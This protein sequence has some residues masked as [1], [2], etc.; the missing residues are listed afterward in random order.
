[1]TFYL[2]VYD[3]VTYGKEIICGYIVFNISIY[4]QNIA[5]LSVNIAI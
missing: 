4:C 2:P 5:L 3:S 1:M